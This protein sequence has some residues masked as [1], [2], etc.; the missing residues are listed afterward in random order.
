MEVEPRGATDVGGNPL[1]TAWQV[2]KP[3]PTFGMYDFKATW[4]DLDQAM[5]ILGVEVND[6]VERLRGHIRDNPMPEGLGDGAHL[7]VYGLRQTA[8]ENYAWAIPTDEALDLLAQL[9]PLV[10]VGAGRGY[11][12]RLLADR[13]ADVVA[14]DVTPPGPGNHWHPEEGTFHPVG[15]AGVEVAAQYPDRTL[16]LCWPPYADPMAEEALAAYEAAG[17]RQL[18]F[19]GEGS[20]GCTATS[21]FFARL[22]EGCDHWEER[23]KGESCSCPAPGWKQVG[24]VGLPQWFGVHDNLWIYE[25]L[26]LEP[27]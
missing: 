18:A 13:G 21:E 11:W 23:E 16:F 27:R 6:E 4:A 19:I 14:Y 20:S 26:E 24:F 10:E 25:R 8:V 2:L 17:G 9:S 1:L 5:A 12:A 22:G 15:Q 3:A 7:A